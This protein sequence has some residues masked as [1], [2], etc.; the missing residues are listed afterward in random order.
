MLRHIAVKCGDAEGTEHHAAEFLQPF[1]DVADPEIKLKCGVD[2]G[3]RSISK[4]D[5]V[6]SRIK[7]NDGHVRHRVGDCADEI[8]PCLVA[9]AE[10]T[11][12]FAEF[13][14]AAEQNQTPVRHRTQRGSRGDIENGD[15]LQQSCLVK[16]AQ[17]MEKPLHPRF[18][19]NAVLRTVLHHVGQGCKL[20]DKFERVEFRF[21]AGDQHLRGIGSDIDGCRNIGYC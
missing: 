21:H 20:V 2:P 17:N 13:A 14:L 11:R 3:S 15:A 12:E 8:Q 18:R 10:K 4:T 7:R 6:E 5:I 9:S 16:F 1:I 19:D